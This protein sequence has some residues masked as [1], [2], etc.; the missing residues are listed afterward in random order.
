MHP[1]TKCDVIHFM[2]FDLSRLI[3]L[4]DVEYHMNTTTVH[5]LVWILYSFD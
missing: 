3:S 5:L 1:M 2:M 4:C